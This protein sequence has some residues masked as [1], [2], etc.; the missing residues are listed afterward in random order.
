MYWAKSNSGSRGGV[1]M[2]CPPP[3][4]WMTRPPPRLLSEGLDLPLKRDQKTEE[5]EQ[6]LF[7]KELKENA[8]VFLAG[9]SLGST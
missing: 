2:A 8:K 3:R 7:K 6:G 1:L 5:L 9:K 4:V